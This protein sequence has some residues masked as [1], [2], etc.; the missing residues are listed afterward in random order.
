MQPIGY[1]QATKT[2][3][4][5]LDA[6]FAALADPTRL[7]ILARPADGDAS[8][9]ELAAP[10]SMSQAAVSKHLR[11]LEKAEPV[12]R[13]RDAQRRPCKLEAKPLADHGA[14]GDVPEVLGSPFQES[15][16]LAGGNEIDAAETQERKRKKEMKMDRPGGVKVAVLGECETLTMRD[17]DAP[18]EMVFDA[19]T[20]PELLR[21]WLLGPD[22]WAMSVCEV[23]LKVG[24]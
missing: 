24:G 7:A 3:S 8:V 11:V 21:R 20:K 18:V 10:F 2:A 16:R 1:G 17:F 12:S 5:R 22:G 19:F 13:G 6:T 4:A 14:A 15:G 9:M 23:D